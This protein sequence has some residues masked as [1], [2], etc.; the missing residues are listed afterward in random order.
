MALCFLNCMSDKNKKTGGDRIGQPLA[1]ATQTPPLLLQLPRC[2]SPLAWPETSASTL[3]CMAQAWPTRAWHVLGFSN[4]S[5]GERRDGQGRSERTSAGSCWDRSPG[6]ENEATPGWRKTGMLS[7]HVN[8]AVPVV[9]SGHHHSPSLFLPQYREE[10]G[11][12]H[13]WTLPRGLRM[14]M[15]V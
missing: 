11:K 12:G 13:A 7:E 1:P 2:H 6:S 5:R 9:P 14:I 4:W 15:K 8:Q 3:G 10:V